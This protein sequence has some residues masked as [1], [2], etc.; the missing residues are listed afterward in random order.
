MI[1]SG[2]AIEPGAMA[3]ERARAGAGRREVVALAS[4]PREL[5]WEAHSLAR[6]ALLDQGF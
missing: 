3:N 1:V 2:G 5:D 4:A 6:E